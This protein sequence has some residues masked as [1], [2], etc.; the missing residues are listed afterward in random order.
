MS[1][2][3]AVVLSDDE[4]LILGV[5]MVLDHCGYD[6]E[7]GVP[8]K[9]ELMELSRSTFPDLAVVD[10]TLAGMAGLTIV[11]ALRQTS[12]RLTV[13]VLCPFENLHDAALEEGAVELLEARDLVGLQRCLERLQAGAPTACTCG[14]IRQ[15][16][17]TSP[18]FDPAN[19][20][21]SPPIRGG[22]GQVQ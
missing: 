22:P 19:S 21:V 2:P 1:R 12:P 18:A 3:R 9:A 17:N 20:R 11:R 16:P 4:D 5:E 10:L 14:L 8:T 15:V 7:A 6:L 13:V